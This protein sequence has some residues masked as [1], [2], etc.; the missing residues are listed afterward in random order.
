MLESLGLTLPAFLALAA[1]TVVVGISKTAMPGAGTLPAAIFA[2]VLPARASTATL[3]VLLILGDAMAMLLYRRHAEW[4]VLL[5]LAP[6]VIAGMILGALFLLVAND[7]GVRRTIAVILLAMIGLTLWLRRRGTPI[8]PG[9]GGPRARA[10]SIGYGSL[11][12]FTTMV[13]NAGGP[14]MSMYFLASGFPVKAFLGTSAWFFAI[15]NLLKVPFA[16]GIGLINAHS[17]LVDAVLAPAV[18]I[19]GVIGWFIAKRINQ[20]VFEI[21]VITLTA[22]SALYLLF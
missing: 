12:G 8:Q 6:A 1:A 11:G 16:A 14:V 20:R 19:G 21:V 4:R 15:V 2:A 22:I 5:R 7:V 13:A 18:L 3:L 9:V 10:M 17:L